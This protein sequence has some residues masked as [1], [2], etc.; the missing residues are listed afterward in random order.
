MESNTDSHGTDSVATENETAGPEA[1]AAPSAPPAKTTTAE[2]RLVPVDQ[3][4]S[5]PLNAEIYGD[6]P[7][8]DLIESIKT[9]GV[10]Q[11]LLGTLGNFILGGH[12]RHAASRKSGL[13]HVPVITVTPED[14]FAEVEILVTANRQR[15]KTN[16]Q[17]AREAAALMKCEQGKARRRQGVSAGGKPVPANSP[18][19]QEPTG[20]ARKIVAAKLKIGQK[21]VDQALAVIEKLDEMK[22]AG[23][24]AQADDLRQRLGKS[25]HRAHQKVIVL[26]KPNLA[27]AQPPTP[28]QPESEESSNAKDKNEIIVGLDCLIDD[29]LKWP[30][31]KLRLFEK[32]LATWLEK[33]KAEYLQGEEAA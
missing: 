21:K 7:S 1:A 18:E 4:K 20:D 12:L 22:A 25:F 2:I 16:E 9:H 15:V 33:W 26:K 32:D 30:I 17:V 28:E 10:L 14:E 31:K 3:L 8:D 6:K 19:L 24:T 11:P 27:L 13:T 29:V 23:D 5:H